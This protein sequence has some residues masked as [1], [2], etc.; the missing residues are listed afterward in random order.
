MTAKWETIQA[1]NKNKRCGRGTRKGR[2]GRLARGLPLDARE[3]VAVTGV[4]ELPAAVFAS[5]LGRPHLLPPSLCTSNAVD[6]LPSLRR[7]SGP[8]SSRLIAYWALDISYLIFTLYNGYAG[9]GPMLRSHT[10]SYPSA[11]PM[12]SS[13]R[14]MVRIRRFYVPWKSRSNIEISQSYVWD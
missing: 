8:V 12:S 14:T 6:A 4:T 10:S 2:R 5:H 13:S 7:T 11:F 3:R 1:V 9:G